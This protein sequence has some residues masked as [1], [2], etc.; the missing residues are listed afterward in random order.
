MA[1]W[2]GAQ[3][4]V[5]AA[6]TPPLVVSPS[7]IPTVNE[8]FFFSISITRLAESV[9]GLNSSLAHAPASN[10]IAK[11]FKKRGFRRT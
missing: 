8:K 11:L 7:K 6:K 3:V 1:Q 5:K 9:E 10:R 2:V 4:Q